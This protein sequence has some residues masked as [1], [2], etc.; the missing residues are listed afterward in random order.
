MCLGA[1]EKY[2]G[3]RKRL[4]YRKSL[5]MV[6]APE[7]TGDGVQS[8]GGGSGQPGEAEARSSEKRLQG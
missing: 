7:K 2:L 3:R 4:R 8:V 6:G 5:R 1:S